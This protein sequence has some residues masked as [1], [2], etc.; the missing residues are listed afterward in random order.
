M[1]VLLRWLGDLSTTA[2]AILGCALDLGRIAGRP[3][4]ELQASSWFCTFVGVTRRGKES[5]KRRDVCKPRHRIHAIVRALIACRPNFFLLITNACHR[6]LV[7][8]T[9]SCV[10]QG[11]CRLAMED[12]VRNIPP[13]CRAE[14]NLHPPA[15]TNWG[16]LGEAP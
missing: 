3:V 11:T 13:G 1:I 2:P 14:V 15:E 4:V 12:I 8:S 6:R 10:R 16:D 5:R 9:M 7:F